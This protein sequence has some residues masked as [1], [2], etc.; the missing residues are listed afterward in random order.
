MKKKLIL[1]VGILIVGLLGGCGKKFDAVAYTK[2]ILDN[3]YKND[4]TDFLFMELGTAEE[5]ADL[6]EQGLDTEVDAML[7][8]AGNVSDAQAQEFRQVFADI[9]AG[10]KYTVDEAEKQDDGSFVVTV[11]YEQMQVFTPAMEQYMDDINDWVAEIQATGNIPSDDEMMERM[12][13]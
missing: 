12:R 6:Y 11:T 7:A 3:S 4:P 13:V 1:A 9:L 10:A 2:A 5:A 8:A